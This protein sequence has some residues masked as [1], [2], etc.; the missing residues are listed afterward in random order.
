MNGFPSL[1]KITIWMENRADFCAS[2]EAIIRLQ[3]KCIYPGH[4]RPMRVYA[5][6]K[7]LVPCAKNALMAPKA[8]IESCVM[9]SS[10]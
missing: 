9:Y 4:G 10:C 8:M 5:L 3:P 1:R 6:A 7:N 2:W